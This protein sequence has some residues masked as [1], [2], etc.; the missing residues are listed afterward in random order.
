M[1][2]KNIFEKKLENDRWNVDVLWRNS[3]AP[4]SHCFYLASRNETIRVIALL[5]SKPEK[6][7]MEI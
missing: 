6:N 5:I 1:H 4:R 2:I 7:E 3:E